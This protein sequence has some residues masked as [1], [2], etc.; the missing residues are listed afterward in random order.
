[1]YFGEGNNTIKTLYLYDNSVI[2][3]ENGNNSVQVSTFDDN[4]SL[5]LGDGANSLKVR[6]MGK[7]SNVF[8]GNG[9]NDI[10]IHTMDS[11]FSLTLGGENNI[12]QVIYANDNAALSLK[13]SM[14]T[15]LQIHNASSKSFLS[16][17][18]MLS[19]L[20]DSEVFGDK[21]KRADFLEQLR[22]DRLSKGLPVTGTSSQAK[23]ENYFLFLESFPDISSIFLTARPQV[24][25][26]KHI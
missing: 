13:K 8:I 3:V 23:V 11:K 4:S 17:D 15:F 26:S 22:N 18:G 6:F 21:E 9:N 5:V 2:N 24:Q 1:M 19:Y 7:N 25:L 10:S 12:L 14:N 16:A 20:K